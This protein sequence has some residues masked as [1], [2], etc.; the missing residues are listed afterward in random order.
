VARKSK[1]FRGPEDPK[2][3][4]NREK[5]SKLAKIEDFGQTPPLDPVLADFDPP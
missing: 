2:I 3:V 1:L 4:K 5:S